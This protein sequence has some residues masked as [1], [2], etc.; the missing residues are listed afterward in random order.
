[1]SRYGAAPQVSLDRAWASARLESLPLEVT[2]GQW[3]APWAR[4]GLIWDRDVDLPG[5]L[6]AVDLSPQEGS[7][8]ELV[9][10]PGLA[11]LAGGSPE[12]QD[13]LWLYAGE[14]R[15]LWSWPDQ[16]LELALGYVG[17][18]SSRRLG[19]A[20]GRGD[21]LV[22]Q[23]PAGFTANT[24]DSDAQDPEAE[25]TR[26]LARNGLASA[27]H[28]VSLW[29]AWRAPLAEALPLRL[30]LQG[31]VNLGAD[32]PG[33]GQR[34]AAELG[35][36]LGQADQAGQGEVTLRGLWIQADAVL[37]AF[38]RELYGTN[39]VGA[40]L[41]ASLMA[42]QGWS[43]GFES[44]VGRRAQESLRGLGSGRAEPGGASGASVQLHVVTKYE[45]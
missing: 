26:R 12:F 29:A 3:G 36:R 38:N 41:D 45:F 30:H 17:V 13:E 42:V 20:I 37:D 43:I 24:T 16:T 9:I 4:D 32:G 28:V 2:V 21:L 8:K 6:L 40:G 27:F 31:A 22:G 14:A 34:W 19:R 35:A 7:L 5:L 1:M 10:N 25:L 44:V 39:L 23:R 15:A 11:Y 33:R 18:N